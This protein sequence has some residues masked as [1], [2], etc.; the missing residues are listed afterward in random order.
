MATGQQEAQGGSNLYQLKSWAND[1]TTCVAQDRGWE[2]LEPELWVQVAR[3]LHSKGCFR[4]IAALSTA[5]R[6]TQHVVQMLQGD[7]RPSIF[8]RR[9]WVAVRQAMHILQSDIVMFPR[10]FPVTLRVQL[11]TASQTKLQLL[12]VWHMGGGQFKVVPCYHLISRPPM[13]VWQQWLQWSRT[14]IA[15]LECEGQYLSFEQTLQV[16]CGQDF[17]SGPPK[18]LRKRVETRSAAIH[19]G[20]G[21][22]LWQKCATLYMG[23]PL[24]WQLGPVNYRGEA[25]TV[26]W[27]WSASD[28]QVNARYIMRIRKQSLMPQ[29]FQPWPKSWIIGVQDN[30]QNTSSAEGEAAGPSC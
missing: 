15:S 3:V 17:W 20:I 30:D 21:S 6:A 10:P 2:V 25:L 18:G 24:S 12:E 7:L 26:D 23:N 5:C 11:P 16:L 9:R 19:A 28:F 14:F 27:E 4:S 29:H 22:W 1:S 8:Y 13:Q